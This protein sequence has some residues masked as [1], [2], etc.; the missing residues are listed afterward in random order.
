MIIPLTEQQIEA[1]RSPQ[2][3]ITILR[4]VTELGD[5]L[6]HPELNRIVTRC[7]VMLE[8]AFASTP[9]PR[10]PPSLP[11]TQAELTAALASRYEADPVE[12]E[13]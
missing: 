11:P 7:V 6:F 2:D 8:T 10:R 5:Q 9:Q 12:S 1:I 4:S 3:A 13:E